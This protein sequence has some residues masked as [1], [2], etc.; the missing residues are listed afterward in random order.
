[1]PY[2]P[3]G[4]PRAG[5]RGTDLFSHI[6]AV[7]Q[8]M[9][10]YFYR[11]D[12]EIVSVVD[13]SGFAKI[14]TADDFVL[15][16]IDVG[17]FV[18]IRN[19]G[20]SFYNGKWQVTSSAPPTEFVINAPY[21]ADSI[22]DGIMLTHKNWFLRCQI[23]VKNDA[24]VFVTVATVDVKHDSN[25]ESICD[26]HSL[27]K[28][29]VVYSDKNDY[30]DPIYIDKFESG[31]YK[32]VSTEWF[33]GVEF[34]GVVT[35]S[36][37]SFTNSALQIQQLYGSNM[38]MFVLHSKT[39]LVPKLLGDFD[40]PT[41]FTEYPFSISLL[42]NYVLEENETF[43]FKNSTGSG[44]S[45]LLIE[46][47]L[48]NRVNLN[49]LL[50]IEEIDFTSM[51]KFVITAYN[52]VELEH[53]PL[54]DLQSID[55]D[56]NCRNSPV[57]LNWLSTDGSRNYWLFEDI[58]QLLKDV[59]GGNSYE[60]P[61][62]NTIDLQNMQTKVV[63]LS[64]SAQ[65]KMTVQATLH[66]DKVKGLNKITNSMNVLMYMGFDEFNEIPIWQQ[67]YIEDGSFKICDTTDS[68]DTIELTL[69]FDSI[70]IQAQ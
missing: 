11:R 7:H 15:D 58:Q 6:N 54:C 35:S 43:M 50:A 5:W 2:S 38:A 28:N 66:V 44:Q 24:S 53:S 29:L 68:T 18:E 52:T 67:V 10:F 33:N 14:T 27:L 31:I 61:L 17:D 47:G 16:D 57:Y 13:E 42:S 62:K 9:G 30:Y 56:S 19:A 23:Q 51:N 48:L 12:F 63:E 59:K 26:V 39:D 64:R 20:E 55:V 8:P 22:G 25:W 37:F 40:T 32:V 49:V 3:N 1:M 46:N 34:G 45:E 69:I 70:N 60:V 21:V 36:E 41:F 4:T 65:P